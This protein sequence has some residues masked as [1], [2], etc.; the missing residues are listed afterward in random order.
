MG[1]PAVFVAHSTDKHST[2]SG[3]VRLASWCFCAKLRFRFHFTFIWPSFLPSFLPS[4][5]PSFLCVALAWFPFFCA[6]LTLAADKELY[7]ALI[8]GGRKAKKPR[9][10]AHTTICSIF[11]TCPQCVHFC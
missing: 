10:T 4:L 9:S 8:V 6:L 11:N 1:H 2:E 5:P 7:A 3:V